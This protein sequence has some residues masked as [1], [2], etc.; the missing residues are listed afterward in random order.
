[1]GGRIATQ[2]AAGGGADDAAGLVLLGYPLHPP[3]KPK[4]RRDAHLPRVG[5]P[6]LFIQGSRDAFGT[7]EELAPVVRGLSRGSRVFVIEGGDHSLVLPK[8]AGIPLAQVIER[9]AGAE[10]IHLALQLLQHAEPEFV[11][12]RALRAEQIIGSRQADLGFGG[13]CSHR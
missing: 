9:V 10:L 12:H 13:Q 2:V 4:Q 5:A 3:G 11:Q 1:M 8:R 6:M 7:P